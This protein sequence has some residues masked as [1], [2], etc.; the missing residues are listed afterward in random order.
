MKTR[1]LLG[2]QVTLGTAL[3][4]LGLVGPRAEDIDLFT[5][6]S[7]DPSNV[8][9]ILDNSSN[10][11]AANQGWPD[12][13]GPPPGVDCGNDCNKQGYYELKAIRKVINN[14]PT[15]NYGTVA[16]NIGLMLFNNSNASRDGAYVRYHVRRMTAFNR[17]ALLAKLDEIIR[18]FNTETASSSVQYA[19][20]LFD[21]FKY[22]GGHTN[23]DSNTNDPP[24]NP[25][26][27]GIPVFGTRYW[28]SNDADGTKPDRYAYDED[29]VNYNPI[30][31]SNCGKNFIVFVGNGFPAKDNTVPDMGEVLRKLT[32]PESPPSTTSEFPL[33]TVT[34][35][36]SSW[37]DAT[38]FSCV[39]KADC[40]GLIPA[41]D[42]TTRYQCAASGCGKNQERVQIATVVDYT[43]TTAAPSGNAVS[44][45]GD[46][47]TDFLYRTDVHPDAGQQNV[48]TYTIDVYR[49]KQDAD[50]TAL[51]RSMASYGKGKYL[52]ATD[53]TSLEEAFA[54]VFSEILSLNAA[55]ASASLPVNVNTQGN[56]LNRVFIGMF[57]PDNNPR[58]PGNMKQ[59]KF[60]LD[61]DDKL[62]LVD[63]TG[64]RAISPTTGFVTPCAV[65]HWTTADTYWSAEPAGGCSEPGTSP[66]SNA[67]DGELVEKGAA[68]QRLRDATTP[69]GRNLKTCDTASC[70]A[71]AAFDVVNTGLSSDLV[72]WVRGANSEP[73]AANPTSVMR[74]SVH[75]DVVHS[76][77]L[78]LDFGTAETPDI[79]VFYGANDGTL[80]AINADRDDTEGTELWSF[81]A[82][83][84][85]A[86][87]SRLEANE[88]VISFPSVPTGI[89]P[90]PEPKDYFFDGSV[91]GYAA[92]GSVWIYA[93]MRRGGRRVYAFD[94]TT[95]GSPSLKWRAGCPNLDLG[96][97]GGC[98]ANLSQIG[99]TWSTV[100]VVLT[101]GYLNSADPPAPKPLA[102]LGGGYDTCE[103]AEPNTCSN[104]KGNR[105]FVFDADNGD[106]LATLSTERSVA[107]DITVLDSGGNGRVDLA[108]VVDTGGNLYRI[109]IGD[110]APGDWT[111]TPVAAVGCNEPPCAARTL[112]RKF[113]SAPEVVVTQQYNAVLVGSGDREHPLPTSRATDVDNA[114]FMVKDKPTD[115]NWLDL[116]RGNCGGEP[117]ICIGADADNSSL[118]KIEPE[119][120][121]PT[122]AELTAAKGWYLA[123]GEDSAKVEHNGEQVVT[124]A[125]VLGGV[126][127]FSTH[128]PTF[129]GGA[130]ADTDGDGVKDSVD[131]C[132]DT[133]TGERVN[134]DGCAEDQA[135]SC[136]SLGTTRGYAV[137]FIT[138]ESPDGTTQRFD[139]FVGGGLPPSPV[140]GIVELDDGQQVPFIIGGRQLDGS[141]SSGLEGQ[142]AS[143]DL[144]GVRSRTYWYLEPTQ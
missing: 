74:P 77:P 96:N 100:Q 122:D 142:K 57:R 141:F 88:P 66:A 52:A 99:Q 14:L 49:D 61:D 70:T 124:S 102:L 144:S 59:Y 17:N 48:T 136:G 28:G 27:S 94:V 127:Y 104:P 43:T 58:W 97:D 36:W 62:F 4:A 125:V 9:I 73:E 38:G 8:L 132:P 3:L 84:H 83:E 93:S 40:S 143:V 21:A 50:Q 140:G 113:L 119:G 115:A 5:A 10:W 64:R 71:L 135:E 80:R 79:K 34:P 12:D 13:E 31:K 41:G 78:A 108:Y 76:R 35:V 51:L 68:A 92:P 63:K 129:P 30:R 19:A 55:F 87:L 15:D 33:V 25:G 45:Y 32:D 133:A 60:V 110:A 120:A 11:S 72:A 90:E 46:E 42:A 22:F 47:F 106:L 7:S 107:A 86:K 1:S 37:S 85:W 81:I 82:P 134:A 75:G 103:D 137:N 23:P 89:E 131:L 128:T 16:M 118:L 126:A 29:H 116:E 123:F 114:F 109:N 67:P 91:G 6:S 24:A 101:A 26:Y 139:E 54:D 2:L 65:S 69:A 111:I 20:A 112:N 95:P 138:A 39:K 56:Y 121:S 98:D 44:R 130:N 53:E 105:V 117:V 18:N